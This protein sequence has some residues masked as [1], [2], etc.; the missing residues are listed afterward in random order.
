M[1]GKLNTDVSISN[2][3]TFPA[4][5]EVEIVNTWSGYDGLFYDCKFPTGHRIT[6]NS[7]RVNITDCSPHIDWEQRR[8]EIA[9]EAVTAIMSNEDFYN[10]VLYEGAE[11]NQR[12]IQTSIASA[13]VVFADALIKELK[14]GD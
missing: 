7:D 9:R 11:H 10:Q 12:Q 5:T 8:Y 3:E 13:A 2:N 4:G 1:K 14:K 6:L